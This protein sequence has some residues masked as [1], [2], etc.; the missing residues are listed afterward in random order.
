MT[1]ELATGQAD[2]RVALLTQHEKGVL[3]EAA[4]WS[5]GLTLQVTTAFDTDQLGTFSGEIQRELT[6]L[7]CARRKAQLA[8]ELTGCRYGLGSEG[9]FGGGPMPGLVSW[10]E[11]ILLLHDTVSKQDIVAVASGPVPLMMLQFIDMDGFERLWAQQM[12][13]QGWMLQREQTWFKG[14]T[15]PAQIRKVLADT[16]WQ[17]GETISLLPDFRAMYC[18]A[19]QQ[20]IRTAAEQLAARLASRC[21]Q[22]DAPDFWQKDVERGLP[23]LDCQLPTRQIKAYLKRCD[24]CGFEV[25]EAVSQTGAEPVW[26]GFCNP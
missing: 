21:P 16:Q 7:A 18:P 11:E 25:R 6:P 1:A 20:H 19:R 12:L 8:A 4:L 13:G 9:S 15:E 24:C 10:D 22:C 26:C 2:N 3:V 5:V 14:L 23:C 17:A